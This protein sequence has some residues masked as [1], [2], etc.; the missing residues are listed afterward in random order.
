MDFALRTLTRGLRSGGSIL[1]YRLLS[2]R[3]NFRL[4]KPGIAEHLAGNFEQI[5]IFGFAFHFIL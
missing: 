1:G 5:D 3:V 2:K 4:S